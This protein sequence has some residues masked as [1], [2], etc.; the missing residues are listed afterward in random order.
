MDGVIRITTAL[1]V[2]TVAAVAAVAAGPFRPT[3]GAN[4]ASV[5]LA[6]LARLHEQAHHQMAARGRRL[7]QA[8]LAAESK[9]PL[10]TVNSWA[11]GTALPRDADSLAAVGAVLAWWAGEDPLPVWKWERLQEADQSAPAARAAR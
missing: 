9:V 11:T 1:A 5:V 8:R 10:T 7:T 3:A 4:V 6:E 2:A